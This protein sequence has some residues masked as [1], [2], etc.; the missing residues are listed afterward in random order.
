MLSAGWAPHHL[1]VKKAHLYYWS[2]IFPWITAPVLNWTRVNLPIQ[3]DRAYCN[4]V[5]FSTISQF[6][7]GWCWAIKLIKPQGSNQGSTVYIVNKNYHYC[8]SVHSLQELCC[9]CI[10]QHTTI[11]G[12]DQLPLPTA[13]KSQIKSYLL[14]NKTQMRIS[15]AGLHQSSTLKSGRKHKIVRPSDSPT[16]CRKS[17]TIS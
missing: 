6:E 11:Y 12:I 5:P 7:P 10:A 2:T 3:I 16:N 15:S 9:R 13:L 17:C 14:T 8:V 4:S 1:C